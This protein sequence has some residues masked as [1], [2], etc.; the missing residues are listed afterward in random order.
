MRYRLA[1]NATQ[2]RQTKQKFARPEEQLSYE[3]GKAVQELPALYTRLLAG[4]ISFVVCGAIA[5]AHFSKIDEVATASGELIVAT[6]VRPVTSIGEGSIL[7]VRIE[8]GDEV[9]KNQVL[10]ERDPDIKQTD[11]ARLMRNAALIR[12]DLQ[13]LNAERQGYSSTGNPL[14]NEL[15][16]SRFQDYQARQASAEAE[17]NRQTAIIKQAQARLSRLRE[18]LD[19]AKI[20]QNNAKS[21]LTNSKIIRDRVKTNQKLAQKR[22]KSLRILAEAAVVSRLDYLAAQERLNLANTEIIK[23]D[24]QIVNA[25][26]RLTQAKDRVKSLEKDIA[27][28]TQEIRQAEQA[29]EAVRSQAQR[30]ASQ[31]QSE[32]LTE[33][34]KRKEELTSI[35]GE[36]ELAKKR[37]NSETIKA[38][39]G[40]TVYNIKATKG[41]VQ[42]GEELLSILPEGEELML[43]VKVR[44]RDI[45]FIRQ[46][47]RTKVKMA[48]FP[49]QEFGTVNGEVV[50]ISPNATVDEELGLVFPTR[51]KLNKD[52]MM[53]KGQ[54]VPFTP[55]MVATGE[56]VTR[57]KSIL[58]FIVEPVTRRFSEAFSVR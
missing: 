56:I 28:Q 19:N 57:K 39:F 50:E 14:Q 15:L 2:A 55:G 37:Q 53:V 4:T 9:A 1:A 30:L 17:A 45:G 51:I 46:G 20:S 58:T 12:Q 32:I 8:E 16:N 31:R 47:M 40:G 21:N 5:W 52:S 38:P 42:S 29:Y 11:V 3:L 25:N 7:N 26:D 24:D 22:E 35:I 54:E 6:Q 23:A 13:R 10:I 36:L 43:Q 49:F 33:I 18:N 48:T 44:N 27:A 41:P 34:N